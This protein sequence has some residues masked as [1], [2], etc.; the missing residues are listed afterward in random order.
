MILTSN[1][2]RD[3]SDALRRRCLYVWIDYPS[4]EQEI[5]ILRARLP[6]INVRLAEAIAQFMQRL[7]EQPLQKVPGVAESL[8][9]AAALVRLH[10]DTL[11]E[12]TIAQTL[13][14][15]VKVQEDWER[16]KAQHTVTPAESEPDYGIG[17]VRAHHG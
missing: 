13:G 6:D 4:P 10:R 3:L 5:A 17:S 8:D 1:R 16:L 2:S 12:R 11:D 9:W 7:R 15:I 14:C